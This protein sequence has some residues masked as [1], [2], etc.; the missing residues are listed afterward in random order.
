M[1]SYDPEGSEG[2]HPVP[3]YVDARPRT[4]LVEAK[5]RLHTVSDQRLQ[6]RPIIT[7]VRESIAYSSYEW[8]FQALS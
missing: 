6:E 4:Y 7:V 5:S 3:M 2:T 1:S 8:V